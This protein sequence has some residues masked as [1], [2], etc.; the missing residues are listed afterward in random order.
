[1]VRYRFAAAI[2]LAALLLLGRGA[3]TFANANAN[4]NTAFNDPTRVDISDLSGLT[5]KTLVFTDP[6][7]DARRAL[8]VLPRHTGRVAIA[9]ASATDQAFP[10][11]H[12][13]RAPPA[14]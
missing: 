6:M 14:V 1:M 13:P 2:A 5:T 9:C 7:D 11:A 3:V 12:C 4:W 8:L 10:G